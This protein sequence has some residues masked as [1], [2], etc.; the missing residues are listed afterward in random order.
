[1]RAFFKSKRFKVLLGFLAGLIALIILTQTFSFVASPI[2]G[3][4]SAITQPISSGARWA[5]DGVSNF[6]ATSRTVRDLE[7]EL[8]ELRAENGR[9]NQDNANLIRDT[10]DLDWLRGFIHMR[11][12]NP[13]IRMLDAT[14]VANDPRDVLFRSFTINLGS[15]DGVSER[16]P[17]VTHQG[18]VGYIHSVTPTT[19]TVMTVLNPNISIAALTRASEETGNVTGHITFAQNDRFIL[20]GLERGSAVSPGEHVVTSVLGENFPSNL[21][22]GIAEEVRV[23]ATDM[24]EYVVVKPAVEFSGLRQVMVITEF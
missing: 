18:V 15:I 16:A 11:Q 22:I 9:L 19:A 5:R 1:M 20:E 14:V 13:E 24:S 23:S 10:Q 7:R 17:V 3:A 6:F 8:E 2:S 21:I 12:E 4:I